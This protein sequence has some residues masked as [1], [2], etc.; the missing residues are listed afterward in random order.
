M[1]FIREGQLL[2]GIHPAAEVV[3]PGL[4]V[5]TTTR[6]GGVSEPPFDSLH[7]EGRFMEKV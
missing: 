6:Y 3:A 7:L 4:E 2:I 1:K 5:L